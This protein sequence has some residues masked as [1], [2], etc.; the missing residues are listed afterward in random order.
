MAARK[1][2][3]SK[4]ISVDIPVGNHTVQINRKDITERIDDLIFDMLYSYDPSAALWKRMDKAVD[5]AINELDDAKLLTMARK[6]VR[7]RISDKLSF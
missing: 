7:A 4:T 3:P 5:T 1:K 6:A 2:A